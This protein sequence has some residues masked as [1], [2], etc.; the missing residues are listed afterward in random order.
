MFRS[1]DI[2]VGFKSESIL[3]LMLQKN[4]LE[5]DQALLFAYSTGRV[6]ANPGSKGRDRPPWKTKRS[7]ILFVVLEA[8]LQGV[9]RGDACPATGCR[10]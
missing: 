2:K 1:Q 9:G 4:G 10:I 3:I 8:P 5:S 7:L 6:R